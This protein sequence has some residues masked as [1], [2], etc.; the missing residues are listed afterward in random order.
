MKRNHQTTNAFI[1]H[2]SA[3]CSCIFPLGGI[4]VPLML[5]HSQKGESEF[6]D[7][8]GKEVVNFNI[9]YLVYKIIL[10]GCLAL[11][12]LYMVVNNFTVIE[13]INFD[14]KFDFEYYIQNNQYYIPLMFMTVFGFF[15]F[16]KATL[17]VIGAL[18][19]KKGENYT[20]PL[21]MQFIK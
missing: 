14:Q 2:L 9:S 4:L 17:I 3:F 18:K 21:T 13:S 1:V 16:V 6:L 19:A 20:Y 12:L 7:N 10:I 15:T 8:Q 11:L 5:W